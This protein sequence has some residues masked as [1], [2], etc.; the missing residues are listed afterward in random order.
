MKRFILGII[1][2]TML[3]SLN[4]EGEASAASYT[5]ENVTAYTAYSESLTYH[6][7]TPVY[8]TTAAVRPLI[9][10]KP[11]SGTKFAK[12]T[13]ITTSTSLSFPDARL[14]NTF[15]V[16]DMG[17]ENCTRDVTQNFFDIYF[18][19]KTVNYTTR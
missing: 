4:F 9:C 3:I 5:D 6:E 12:G 8:Y 10:G 2:S 16:Y 11:T 19:K 13:I 17:D 1:L 18:G 7:T 14:R 15:S